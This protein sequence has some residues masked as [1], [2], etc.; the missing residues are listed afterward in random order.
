MT[1]RERYQISFQ[2]QIT[3]RNRVYNFAHTDNLVYG[4]IAG[5]LTNS[6]KIYV[7]AQLK[8]IIKEQEGAGSDF[9][10]GEVLGSG[11]Y[12]HSNGTVEVGEGGTIL[13]LQ[14]FKEL[15]QEW[16]VFISQ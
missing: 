10:W 1:K 4:D 16:L 7:N 14:D 12:F 13:P 11:L 2:K 3:P 9:F 15:L 8:A 6:D 5:H